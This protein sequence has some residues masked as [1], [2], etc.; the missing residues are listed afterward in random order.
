MKISLIAAIDENNGIGKENKLLCHLPNDMKHFKN[1][2]TGHVVIMGRKTYESLGKY[3]PL[4]NRTNFVISRNPEL[5]FEG[6]TVYHSLNKAIVE[7]LQ[8]G[9][10]EV[11]IIGGGEIYKEAIKIAHKLYITKIHHTFEPDTFFPM[12]HTSSWRETKR[13]DFTADEKHAYDYSIIEYEVT[14]GVVLNRFI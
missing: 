9:V 11:F 12:I 13:E 4:P 10:K 5:V 2:T 14:S 7:A 8:L 6:A 3:A 1:T